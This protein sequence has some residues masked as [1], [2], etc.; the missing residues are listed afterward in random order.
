MRNNSTINSERS[1]PQ[2]QLPH[3]LAEVVAGWDEVFRQMRKAGCPPAVAA[4]IRQQF[5]VA[6]AETLAESKRRDFLL[7]A[8]K[9]NVQKLKLKRGCSDFPSDTPETLDQVERCA[10]QLRD[11]GEKRI[12]LRGVE[13]LRKSYSAL[14]VDGV[15][16]GCGR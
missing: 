5:E 12:M 9:Q 6:L 11:E 2:R 10:S 8:I 4:R 14:A 16:E 3:P 1:T 15:P 13:R 7:C